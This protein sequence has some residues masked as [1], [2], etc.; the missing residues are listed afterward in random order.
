[1]HVY[2][3]HRKS[4]VHRERK[5]KKK[6]KKKSFN[7]ARQ[8]K[9]DSTACMRLSTSW[10]DDKEADVTFLR[11]PAPLIDQRL[12]LVICF[13]LLLPVILGVMS[14]NVFL[15]WLMLHKH[16]IQEQQPEPWLKAWGNPQVR[17]VSLLVH[18]PWKRPRQCLGTQ[19]T[20]PVLAYLK[21]V[22]LYKQALHL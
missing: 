22:N 8:K 18:V 15:G 2:I 11:M 4:L 10:L 16:L 13:H 21:N 14:Q 12:W 6:K 5:K 9:L 19:S 7:R 17:V 1:M 3:R 20:T